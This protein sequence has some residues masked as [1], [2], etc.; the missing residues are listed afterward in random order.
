MPAYDLARG[1]GAAR[2][3]QTGPPTTCLAAMGGCIPTGTD[4]CSPR[5]PSPRVWKPI[6]LGRP[7]R[8]PVASSRDSR[9]ADNSVAGL[10]PGGTARHSW[11]D[12]GSR[13]G[14]QVATVTATDSPGSSFEVWP[15]LAQARAGRVLGSRAVGVQPTPE[16]VCKPSQPARLTGR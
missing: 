5:T 16:N 9:S 11:H 4:T 10:P 2:V 14:L 3:R 6:M 7:M 12:G 13:L 8:A 15:R 1:L